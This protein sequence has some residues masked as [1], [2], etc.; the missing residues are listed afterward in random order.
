MSHST[1]QWPPENRSPHSYSHIVI[2]GIMNNFLALSQGVLVFHIKLL[3]LSTLVGGI[4]TNCSIKT[5]EADM[6]LNFDFTSANVNNKIIMKAEALREAFNEA[7][8]RSEV[9]EILMSPDKPHFR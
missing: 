1:R 6:T 2:F 4:V 5:M 3:A 8:S 9:I 7:D